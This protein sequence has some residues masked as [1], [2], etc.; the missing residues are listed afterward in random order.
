MVYFLML[1]LE[2]FEGRKAV[3]HRGPPWLASEELSK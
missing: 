3:D 1:S 2:Y